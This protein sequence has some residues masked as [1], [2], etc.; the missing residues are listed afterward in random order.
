MPR[1][2]ENEVIAYAFNAS[3]DLFA[4][5][6]APFE[7]QKQAC[8]R[9]HGAMLGLKHLTWGTPEAKT[10][11][12]ID[13]LIKANAAGKISDKATATELIEICKRRGLPTYEHEMVLNQIRATEHLDPKNAARNDFYNSPRHFNT[14]MSFNEFKNKK[15]RKAKNNN[16]LSAGIKPIHIKPIGI[17]PFAPAS[18]RKA[19]KRFFDPLEAIFGKQKKIN[20]KGGF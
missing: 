11:N 1:K 12:R 3:R 6:N 20:K 2:E 16:I 17:N 8:N 7:I 14:E 10:I 13:Y 9:C 19:L 18:K 4:L 5:S 15:K